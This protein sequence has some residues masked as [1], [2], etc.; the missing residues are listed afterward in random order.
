M[1]AISSNSSNSNNCPLLPLREDR[2]GKVVANKWDV[3]VS[4]RQG[5]KKQKERRKINVKGV[6]FGS[7]EIR[8]YDRICGEHPSCSSCDPLSIGWDVLE[9]ISLPVEEYENA[10]NAIHLG[11]DF[12]LT[13][14]ERRNI[15]ISLCCVAALLQRLPH[16]SCSFLNALA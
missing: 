7:V 5:L 6:T 15:L 2:A 11:G 12:L 14:R 1:Q 16:S 3:R 8:L 9:C 4:R 13:A 10:R